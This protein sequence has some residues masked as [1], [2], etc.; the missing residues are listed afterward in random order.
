[1]FLIVLLIPFYLLAESLTITSNQM[2]YNDK[3]KISVAEGE[4][5]ATINR[6]DGE[7]VLKAQ[8][9]ILYHNDSNQSLENVKTIKAEGKVE[10]INTQSE[11]K[12]DSCL[13]D[14]QQEVIKCHGQVH[15]FDLKKKD[16]ILG[17]E[18]EMDLKNKVYKVKSLNKNAKAII[19]TQS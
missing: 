10:F 9:L 13:Y 17:D 15:I 19:H 14:S 11:L 7:H 12:A 18:G 5:V 8:K 6:P 16:S 2:I 1:M 4:V 3:E